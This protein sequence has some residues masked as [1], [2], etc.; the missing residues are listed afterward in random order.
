MDG[1]N[2]IVASIVYIAGTSFHVPVYK[3]Q[4]SNT[5]RHSLLCTQMASFRPNGQVL[6]GVNAWQKAHSNGACMVYLRE[7][8]LEPILFCVDVASEYLKMGLSSK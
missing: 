6:A 4:I 7:L 1:D 2:L 5:F 3:C 8:I